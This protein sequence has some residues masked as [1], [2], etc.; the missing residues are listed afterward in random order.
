MTRQEI[1]ELLAKAHRSVAAAERLL[2]GGDSD[3]AVSRAYYAMFYAARALLLTRDIRCSKHSSVIAAF[4]QQFVRE[5]KVSHQY[6]IG[7]RDAFD[8]RAEGDY[9]L[10]VIS[11]EQAEAGIAA[12]RAF[13]K[14]IARII[15]EM[16]GG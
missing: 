2:A 12:A 14:E 9:G 3:F 8:D 1:D 6:F 5:G 15:S 10:A 13:V 11:V 7:L 16:P 4:N